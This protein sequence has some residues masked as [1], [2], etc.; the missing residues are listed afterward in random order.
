MTAQM[1]ERLVYEGEDVSM[2]TCPMIPAGHPR[3][4][5]I[6]PFAPGFAA[7]PEDAGVLYSTGCW[8]QY[9][10]SWEVRNGRLFLVGLRGCFHLRDGEPLLADWWSGILCIPRGALLEYVHMGFESAYEREQLVEVREGMVVGSREID[11]RHRPGKP[12]GHRSQV[13]W[14]RLRGWATRL[15]K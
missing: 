12:G 8:R 4:E 2:T 11:N 9:Q 7:S 15:S 6:D 5:A 10:G 14:Q 13:W 1:H 3:I